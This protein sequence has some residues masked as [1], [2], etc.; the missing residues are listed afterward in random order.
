MVG[1]RTLR[2]DDAHTGIIAWALAGPV[3][4]VLNL[5]ACPTRLSVT[6]ITGPPYIN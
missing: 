4:V 5:G 2:Y 3:D 1:G 6:N